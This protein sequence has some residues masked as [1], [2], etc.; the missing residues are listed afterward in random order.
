MFQWCF[1]YVLYQ[2]VKKQDREIDVVILNSFA[3]GRRLPI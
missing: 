3:V 2:T 1:E